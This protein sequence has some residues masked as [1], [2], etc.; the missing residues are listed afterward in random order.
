MVGCWRIVVRE[1]TPLGSVGRRSTPEIRTPAHLWSRSLLLLEPVSITA[2]KSAVP[3]ACVFPVTGGPVEVVWW[4]RLCIP[5]VVVVVNVG[6][7]PLWVV[8]LL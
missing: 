7:C 1:G 5:G 3:V 4:R 8:L 6:L 2:H